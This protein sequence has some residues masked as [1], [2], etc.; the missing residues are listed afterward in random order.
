MCR[1]KLIGQ[2]E[3]IMFLSAAGTLVY[4]KLEKGETVTVDSRSVLAF[5]DSV[6]LGITPNGR[7]CTC[8]ICG[9]EGCCSTTLTGPGKVSATFREVQF[10]SSRTIT[11]SRL[12]LLSIQVFMQSMNFTKF[13]EAV[14]VTVMEDDTRGGGGGDK[15]GIH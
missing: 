14:Q 13:K 4:K 8:T 5:E 7:C 3:S 2:N 11:K 10:L 1:Q 6:T 15:F 12:T 9:G